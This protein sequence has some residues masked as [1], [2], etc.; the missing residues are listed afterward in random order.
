MR[1][2]EPNTVRHS[3]GSI[4][5]L[6]DVSLMPSGMI[7]LTL[8]LRKKIISWRTPV[9]RSNLDRGTLFICGRMVVIV[10]RRQEIQVSG[11]VS[12]IKKLSVISMH[13]EPDPQ[14]NATDA[15]AVRKLG[16]RASWW[17]RR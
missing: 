13:S 14:I 4:R 8:H 1:E 2:P 10:I 6:W 9:S 7:I 15:R 16:I 3:V 11:M 5:H 12:W 17:L